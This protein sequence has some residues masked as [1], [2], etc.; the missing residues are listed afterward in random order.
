VK[1]RLPRDLGEVPILVYILYYDA[2]TLRLA[3]AAFGN[4][5]WARLL[6]VETGPFLESRVFVTALKVRSPW[7]KFKFC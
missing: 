5:S 7:Q 6:Q 3:R 1:E 2:V 4:I